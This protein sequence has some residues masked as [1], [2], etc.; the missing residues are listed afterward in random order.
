MS[1][2]LSYYNFL[3]KLSTTNQKA[4]F[5]ISFCHWLAS[6]ELFISWETILINPCK[7][8]INQCNFRGFGVA[9]KLLNIQG[10]PSQNAIC[11]SFFKITK[12]IQRLPLALKFTMNLIWLYKK[13]FKNLHFYLVNIWCIALILE[14]FRKVGNTWNR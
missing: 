6:Q 9:N 1:R 7:D 14:S 5:W 3:H 10:T 12:K 13:W 2:D 11:E 4:G 8:F